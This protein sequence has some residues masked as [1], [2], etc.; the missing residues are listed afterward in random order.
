LN[1]QDEPERFLVYLHDITETALEEKVLSR[2]RC[3]THPG[4]HHGARLTGARFLEQRRRKTLWLGERRSPGRGSIVL[5]AGPAMA[6]SVWKN[7]RN[8]NGAA[9][10]KKRAK[11]QDA[12]RPKPL[13]SVEKPRVAQS[14]LIVDTDITE[15]NRW[16][17]SFWFS[18]LENVAAGHGIAHELNN[19]LAPI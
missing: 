3:S 6:R 14:I 12:R 19:I 11:R 4:R 2:R 13:D 5:S 1:S 17:P 9:N 18:R 7:L 15:K 16:R 8:A 10:W